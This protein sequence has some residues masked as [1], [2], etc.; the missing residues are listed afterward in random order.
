MHGVK[1][2]AKPEPWVL[3]SEDNRAKLFLVFL[4][5]KH[6]HTEKEVK[7][8]SNHMGKESGTLSAKVGKVS[9]LVS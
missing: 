4:C 6:T 1:P 8:L 5:H 7:Q 2:V 9:R 3:N